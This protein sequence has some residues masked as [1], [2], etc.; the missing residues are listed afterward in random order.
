MKLFGFLKPTPFPIPLSFEIEEASLSNLNVEQQL[1]LCKSMSQ[2]VTFIWGPPGTGKTKT[3]SSILNILIKARRRVLLTAN[4]NR[5]VDEILKKFVEAPENQSLIQEG[6]IVRL[7]IPDDEDESLDC[8]LFEKVAEKRAIKIQETVSEINA[9]IESIQKISRNYREIENSALERMIQREHQI[10]EHKKIEQEI[11]SLQSRI[12]VVRANLGNIEASLS[13]KFQLLA[14]VKTASSIR[15]FLSSMNKEQI[16]LDISSIKN[17]Q[18][19]AR[20][21]LESLERQIDDR[22]RE[23][24]VISG[25]IN[26]YRNEIEPAVDGLTTLKSLHQKISDLNGEIENKKTQ[27]DMLQRQMDGVKANVFNEALVIGSTIARACLDPKTANKKFETFIVDEA[28]MASLPNM[29]FLA[30]LCSTHYIISGDFRQLSPIARCRSRVAQQWLRRDIYD[31]AG[32]VESVDSGILDDERLVMLK[33]QYRMHPAICSLVSDAVYERKLKTPDEV[34]A[35]KGKLATLSPF[36]GR[37]L[38]FCDTA[39]IDPLITRPENTYSRLSPYS[40]AFS[41]RLAA[42][43]LEEGEKNGVKLSVGIITP[44]KE[45]AKLISRILEDEGLDSSCAVAS[46]IH[47]FQGSEKDYIIFDLVEGEPLDPG[48]LTEGAFKNSEAGKLLTVAISRAMGK[49]ILVGNSEYIKSRFLPS[50]A[51]HQVLE[52]IT[53]I[54]GASVDSC[55]VERTFND[56]YTSEEIQ[57]LNC[58]PIPTFDQTDFYEAFKSD[59]KK[60]KSRLVIFSPFVSRKRVTDL[61]PDFQEILGRNVPIY[62]VTRSPEYC[63]NFKS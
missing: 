37:A 11:A 26:Q 47:R 46:T 43:C 39:I 6:K 16:E 5:A 45:Q 31:Q 1:A 49:F 13:N 34:S 28:S 25:R 41:S 55:E 51:V 38:V 42:K 20:L 4:T 17:K 35:S 9:Q 62:I 40:A 24:N 59:M 61:L 29:F 10:H 63:G 33:E 60:A 57:R 21:E 22:I 15:R 19:I 32:I 44:Y 48:R 58:L 14:K 30:G 36:K 56:G 8:I 27:I 23:R 12:S 52:K 50:D 3:L 53:Q 7:G 18:A 2:E 54:E